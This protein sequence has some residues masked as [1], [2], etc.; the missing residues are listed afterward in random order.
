M[1][2]KRIL[3]ISL[4]MFIAFSIVFL[5]HKEFSKKTHDNATTYAEIELNRRVR[6]RV[7]LRL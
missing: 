6:K 3:S 4:L 5:V 1:N 2:S 7:H